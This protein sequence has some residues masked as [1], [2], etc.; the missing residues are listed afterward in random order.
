MNKLIHGIL[1]SVLAI[2]A[3]QAKTYSNQT[4]LR[5]RD[6]LFYNHGLTAMGQSCTQDGKKSRFGTTVSVAGY[7]RSSHNQSDVAKYFGGGQEVNGDQNGTI[8][9]LEAK[10]DGMTA[11]G[12]NDTISGT[13]M[14]H[15]DNGGLGSADA[16]YHGTITLAP[17]YQEAGAH[18]TVAKDLSH[19][20]NGLH[21]IADLPIARVETNIGATTGEAKIR[22]YLQ[23]LY[24]A[25]G[26]DAQVALTHGHMDNTK[27]ALTRLADLGI[28]LQYRLRDERAE[29]LH[30]GVD[31]TVPTGNR[32]DAVNMYSPQAGNG[33]HFGLGA[34]AHYSHRLWQSATRPQGLDLFADAKYRYLFSADQTRI[35]GVYNHQFNRMQTA[36]HYRNIGKAG[37]NAAT[38]AANVLK[39]LMLVTPGSEF[40]GLVGLKYHYKNFSLFAAYNLYAREHEEA[41]LKTGSQ[42][43]N[44][45]YAAIDNDQTMTD[46]LIVGKNSDTIDSY[47]QKEGETANQ[48]LD[49]NGDAIGDEN[50]RAY[51]YVT[52]AAA[53]SPS[54]VTHMVAGAAEMHC[55]KFKFPIS[56]S[57]GGS[58]EFDHRDDN[59]G[60]HCWSA[61]GKISA[62]F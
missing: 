19:A 33:K 39:R 56:V 1:L 27:R 3:V 10:A 2:S 11:E 21:I 13:T 8:V 38:P 34:S 20:L 7:Y 55:N 53:Q 61:W 28:K 51:Y 47:I 25:T 46:D 23:G 54:D 35:L 5:H 59:R 24:T 4:S 31:F 17:T 60:A 43:F 36:G 44:N 42:W 22:E 30:V 52:T 26:V 9:V 32:T 14:F 15:N 37:A 62:C 16:L 40:S 45:E 57:A 12:R 41:K 49:T 50:N 6:T 48:T 29:K 18:I 58:Y